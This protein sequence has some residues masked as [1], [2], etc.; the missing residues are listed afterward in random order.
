MEKI[1]GITQQ[2]DL[3]VLIHAHIC[4][5]DYVHALSAD[6]VNPLIMDVNP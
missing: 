2:K 1:F 5:L 6:E 3:N 4:V